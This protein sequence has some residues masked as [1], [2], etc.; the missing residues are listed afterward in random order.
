VVKSAAGY[1]GWYAPSQAG[2][3]TIRVSLPREEAQRV[4]KA[5]V[6]DGAIEIKGASA[7]GKPLRWV[8]KLG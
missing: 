7:P 5:E 3:W 8:V 1:E 2:T 4:R 6:R